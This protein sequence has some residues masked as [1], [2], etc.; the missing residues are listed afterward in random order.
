[1]T[2]SLSLFCPAKLNLHLRIVGR[3]SDGYHLLETLFH[4]I[5]L[6]DDLSCAR[7]SGALS[8]AITAD[9]P[10]DALP[11]QDDN[12]VLRAARAFANAARVD[13]SFSFTL[14]KRVPH[15]GGLGGGSSDAA[16]ALRLCNAMCGEPLDRNAMLELARPLGADVAFFLDGGTQWGTGVGD[17]LQP[18]SNPPSLWFTLLVPPFG[19]PT[20]DVYKTRA[21]MWKGSDAADS[22]PHVRD[23]L[24]DVAPATLR[25]EIVND[26]AASAELV[27]PQLALLRERA[28]GLSVGN[29]AMTGSGSTLFVVADSER[30]AAEHRERLRPLCADGVRILGARSL[31]ASPQ[32]RTATA[33]TSRGGIA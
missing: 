5:D 29:V 16:A 14:H 21:L 6:G 9:D 17:T 24:H 1:V 32:V 28:E 25:G 13:P 20:A 2:A 27:R 10:R 22:M 19:C 12:L 11:V 8:L 3:R 33:A 23:H 26:L 7:S 15:G 18:V 31:G 30:L 4:A